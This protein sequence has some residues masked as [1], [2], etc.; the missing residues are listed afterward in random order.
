VRSEASSGKALMSRFEDII[1][2]RS[3]VC[4]LWDHG[5]SFC[6]VLLVGLESS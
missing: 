6:L 3:S 4:S 1:M 5:V 2:V